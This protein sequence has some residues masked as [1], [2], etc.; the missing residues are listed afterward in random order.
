MNDVVEAELV[1]Y[2]LRVDSEFIP[3]SINPPG[4]QAN[5]TF[6]GVP[7]VLH[8]RAGRIFAFSGP[9]SF[10]EPRTLSFELTATDPTFMRDVQIK[11]KDEFTGLPVFS[12]S[13]ELSHFR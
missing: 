12:E 2:M 5:V 11:G 4:E 7:G 9:G 6:S 1:G 3:G 13:L 8:W 10:H